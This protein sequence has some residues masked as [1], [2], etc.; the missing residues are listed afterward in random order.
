MF[1][2]PGAKIWNMDETGIILDHKPSKVL[3]RSSTT[4]LYSRS[5]GNN[6]MIRGTATV[7]A[8]ERKPS[9]HMIYKGKTTRALN[10]FEF[11]AAPEGTT[12]S[13][14][15][16]FEKQFLPNIGNERSQSLIVDCHDLH[17]LSN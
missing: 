9:P 15:D 3:G 5:S 7:N 4:S 2:K 16:R 10:S 14:S 11:E 13:V 8:A 6:E 12:W 1:N 17:N